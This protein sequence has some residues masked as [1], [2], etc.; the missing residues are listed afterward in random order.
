MQKEEC[1]IN[2]GTFKTF[3]CSLSTEIC[4]CKVTLTLTVSWKWRHVHCVCN[5]QSELNT[6]QRQPAFSADY[7]R[8]GDFKHIYLYSVHVERF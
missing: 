6:A 2:N 3:V 1:P 4:V 5:V 7:K 8:L